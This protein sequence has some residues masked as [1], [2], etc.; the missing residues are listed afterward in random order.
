VA[1]ATAVEAVAWLG[2][3]AMGTPMVRRLAASG[4]AVTAYDPSAAHVAQLGAGVR[5]APAPV[6][7]ARDCDVLVLMVASPEQAEVAVFGPDGAAAV[8]APGSRVVVLG[9]LGSAWVTDLAAR[10]PAGVRVVDAPV[11]G[12][13]VRAADGSLLVMAAGARAVD[14]AL[15][16]VLGEVV[17]VGTQPGQGQ[18]MKMVNQV[19]CGVHIAAAAEALA[20]AEAM[21]IDPAAAWRT[22]RR[23]AAASFMLEDR[24]ARMV[25]PRE[26]GVRSA[27]SLF[28]KDLHLVLDEARA[29]GLPAP[30]VTAAAGLFADAAAA[31]LARHDDTGLYDHL[32]SLRAAATRDERPDPDGS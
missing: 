29:A 30:V 28:V 5:A 19:L 14:V 3:G 13:V 12:G 24:G 25:G 11:S 23:G 32:R 6:A 2:V 22:V 10:L 21:G 18:A 15:L 20:L 1:D 31:G 4:Y 16:S 7:A 27:V 26:D 8:L 9:T 17:E